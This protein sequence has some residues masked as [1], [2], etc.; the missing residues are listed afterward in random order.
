[1]GK[2]ILVK[3]LRTS[4]GIT[5]F[6]AAIVP[7]KISRTLVAGVSLE[8]SSPM[9]DAGH[10]ID[11]STLKAWESHAKE[12]GRSVLLALDVALGSDFY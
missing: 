4:S 12:V 7:V 3:K 2:T 9:R 11:C 10:S 6:S 5:L 8:P 1:M